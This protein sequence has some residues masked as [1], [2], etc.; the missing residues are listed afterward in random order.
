MNPPSSVAAQIARLPTLPMDELW[1][2]WD[3]FFPQRPRNHH[4]DYVASRVAYKLQERAFGALSPAVRR[5]LEKIGETGAVPNQK[6]RG[7]ISLAA[8]T[9]LV[10][11]FN[12][13]EH[14]VAVLPD[15]QLDYLG[16]R[17]RSLSAVARAIAGTSWSGP[18]F[19]GLK[20]AQ[21]KRGAATK[22]E[23]RP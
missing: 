17:F 23:G 20:S 7:E 19:F 22:Q 14:R 12:G 16:Q 6:R 2:L 3:Q 4:R 10:R 11:E 1:S 13:V 9:V 15:G 5:K 8:G 21:A 18:A